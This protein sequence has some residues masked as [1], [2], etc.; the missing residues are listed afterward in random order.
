[1]NSEVE[2]TPGFNRRMTTIDTPDAFEMTAY[3][4]PART[5]Q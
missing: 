3:V 4:S 2:L 5:V 1:M